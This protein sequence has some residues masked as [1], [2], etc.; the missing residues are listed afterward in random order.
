MQTK[1]VHNDQPG[2]SLIVSALTQACFNFDP[3]RAAGNTVITFSCGGRADGEGQVT[4]SQL[5]PFQG[6]AGPLALAPKN[7]NGK[8]CFAVKGDVVDSAPCAAGDASQVRRAFF[9]CS[10]RVGGARLTGV[11]WQTFTFA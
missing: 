8:T 7:D 2:Q 5:F 10:L 4:N 6:G 11:R 1:G 9:L 3:R